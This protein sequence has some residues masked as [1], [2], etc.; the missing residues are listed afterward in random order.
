MQTKIRN[1]GVTT[2][3]FALL[4]I[5][6]VGIGTVSADGPAWAANSGWDA[7]D[8]VG[9]GA[10]PAF[11]DLDADGDYDLFIG[12]QMGVSFAYENTGSASSPAWTKKSSWDLPGVNSG[13]KPAFADL[14]ND[15]DYD[16]LIGDG[17]TATA[18]AYENTG[19]ATSPAWTPN[20][21]WNSPTLSW[22]GCKPALADLDNDGDYDLLLYAASNG[23]RAVYEN[24]GGAGSPIWTANP[25][26]NPPIMV[27][28]ATPDFAD[29]DGD[30][31]YDLM[32]GINAGGATSAY[33]NT[34]GASSP[35]WARKSIW[36]P[37]S[38]TMSAK[39]AL[40]DLDNDGDYD[41]LLGTQMG[42]TY[43]FENTASLPS[44]AIYVNETGWWYD[45]QQFNAS[46]TPIQSAVNNA[47]AGDTVIIKDGTYTENVA[48]ETSSLT[49]RS[50]NGSD[51]TTVHAA[52]TWVHVF[53]VTA[54]HVNMSELT[55]TG[56]RYSL[57]AGI[58]L[59]D[60]SNCNISNNV[61][62]DNFFGIYLAD[63]SSN[64][65]VSNN[66]A[67]SNLRPGIV[68]HGAFNNRIFNNTAYGNGGSG[69]A[70]SWASHNNTLSNNTIYSGYVGIGSGQGAYNNRICNNRIRDITESGVRII[71][72]THNSSIYNNN[73]SSC[74]VG[75]EITKSFDNMVYNN[76][77][78]DSGNGTAFTE[79]SGNRVY[80][81]NF[82]NNTNEV[83][84]VD[85]TDNLCN[86]TDEVR[87]TYNNVT[88]TEYLG[89]YWDDYQ[90]DDGDG[91]GIGDTSFD[92]GYA[93]DDHPLVKRFENYRIVSPSPAFTTADAAIALEIA[94]GGHP[95]DSELDVNGDG[96]VTSLDA[97]MILQ[98]ATGNI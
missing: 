81:N 16:V 17:P 57:V 85:S 79:S 13:S 35:V 83:Y 48:V 77:I 24:T 63:N 39:P 32:V 44:P 92:M 27:Q 67:Y 96:V 50:E 45:G 64:S 49:I 6:S 69:C 86:S 21:G 4:L 1:Y 14:D 28:G 10:A 11:V 8:D 97:L 53:R 52:R 89:N 3:L 80:L 62:T 70:L 36:D 94:V 12:E 25:G 75:I 23:K 66:L 72:G 41:L 19:S 55:V 54:S 51:H 61:A 56:T 73:I 38:V 40:A 65:I 43:G 37:P 82:I 18:Y 78:S 95:F 2:A 47:T 71:Y 88:Y 91:N 68:L 46:S 20:S 30:G 74:G 26:W 87:Y 31:D 15:G 59:K 7:P 76:N 33:E 34:G 29:L 58:C 90:G 22:G 9:M 93:T 5:L 84:S 60:A 42:V 98:A